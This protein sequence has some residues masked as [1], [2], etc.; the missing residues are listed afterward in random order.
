MSHDIRVRF[1]IGTVQNFIG[2]RRNRFFKRYGETDKCQML[3]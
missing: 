2:N 3:R 1:G